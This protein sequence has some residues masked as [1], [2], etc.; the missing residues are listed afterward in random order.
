MIFIADKIPSE[1]QGIV[2]L[3]V[4]FLNVSMNPIEVRA[5][6]IKQYTGQRLKMLIPRLL[7]QRTEAQQEIFSAMRLEPEWDELTALTFFQE[8]EAV[9]SDHLS[10]IV[11]SILRW[12][13]S[14]KLYIYP[15]QDTI[16]SFILI[17][18][19]KEKS[20]QL[21]SVR[22]SGLCEICF[23]Y[24]NKSPFDAREKR[25]EFLNR[26][27][28]IEGLSIFLDSINGRSEISLSALKNEAAIKRFLEVFTWVVEEI[29]QS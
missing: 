19:H 25:I 2:K 8:L 5:P 27:N 14:E 6:R 28:S 22:S 29:K 3:L 7:G 1:L 9:D 24:I 18:L 15:K 11:R 21:L 12:A 4:E 23:R 10:D 13:D 17:L 16:K 20:Y 26:L